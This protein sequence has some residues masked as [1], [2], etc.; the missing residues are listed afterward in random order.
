[1]N[2]DGLVARVYMALWAH[3]SNCTSRLKIC[4]RTIYIHWR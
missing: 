1:M 3:C 2:K 4:L